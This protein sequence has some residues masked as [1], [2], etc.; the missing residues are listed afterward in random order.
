[1]QRIVRATLVALGIMP[2]SLFADSADYSL[3]ES[4]SESRLIV[5]AEQGKYFGGSADAMIPLLG[6]QEHLLYTDLQAYQYGKQYRT[7]GAGLGYRQIWGEAIYGMYGFYD[8]QRSENRQ[9]YRRVNVGFERLSETWD[10][11][12]NYSLQVGKEKVIIL[13]QGL[14]ASSYSGNSITNRHDYDREEVYDGGSVEV[15][16]TLGSQALRGFVG[17]YAY[18]SNI[19][20]ASARFEYQLNDR[21]TLTANGQHDDA[22]GWLASGGVQYWIGKTGNT[23]KH[24]SLSNRLRDKV[25]RDMTVAAKVDFD[26][27]VLEA[28]P[29]KI[30]FV[31]SDA[32]AATNG[33]EATPTTISDALSKAAA[34]DIIYLQ[35]G[36]YTLT[37]ATTINNGRTLWGSG[38]DL[39]LPN[40]VVI[41]SGLSSTRPTIDG[42]GLTVDGD[43]TL[44][45]FSVVGD[46]TVNMANGINVTN[47][48]ATIDGV[49]MTG[50]FTNAGIQ[51]IGSGAS[52]TIKNSNIFN[53]VGVGESANAIFVQNGAVGHISDT[54]VRSLSR[55]GIYI[56]EAGGTSTVT[57]VIANS[58]NN[59]GIR[60]YSSNATI[61]GG[62]MNSNTGSGLAIDEAS[63]VTIDGVTSSSNGAF[64]LAVQNG[65][66]VT[67]ID[68]IFNSNTSS[69]IYANQSNTTIALSGANQ[70]K[71]NQEAGIF[72]SN[73]A[74]V[75]MTGGTIT[76]NTEQAIDVTNDASVAITSP[77]SLVG[78]IKTDD[79]NGASITING[80]SEL[81]EVTSKTCTISG[82]SV[83]CTTP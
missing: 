73:N 58:N 81:T 22:R 31:S 49:F 7:L 51:V 56:L 55:Y 21:I 27:H 17:G 61:S 20:G 48:V 39:T 4:L 41:K 59:H 74:V 68:S 80:T 82:D 44:G 76:G 52:A 8:W 29:R 42:F 37:E 3:S 63:T 45:G 50:S 26:H 62:T 70:I 13:D 79:I 57:N 15:G 9:E 5:A 46:G 36:S 35:N 60:V 83:S 71:G 12:A 2:L 19:R 32:T 38:Q 16:R 11:R 78:Q 28:D 54:T 33:Y 53:E 40:G 67:V 75:T 65:S 23:S 24:F 72:A 43:A 18:G 34:D 25:V 14:T 47:G 64:G 6:S 10:V 1:M 30:Y 66:S 77:I 69:G